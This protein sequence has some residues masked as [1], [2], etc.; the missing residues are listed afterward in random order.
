MQVIPVSRGAYGDDVVSST[1]FDAVTAATTLREQGVVLVPDAFA[2][3]APGLAEVVRGH[4]ARR[5]GID[6][7]DATTWGRPFDGGI[8]VKRFRHPE[9][10]NAVLAPQVRSVLNEALGTGRWT[11]EPASARVLVTPPRQRSH[12]QVP[13]GFH[14]DVPID[15]RAWPGHGVLLFSFLA[16]TPPGGG[17]TCVVPGSHQLIDSFLG[18]HHDLPLDRRLKV[19]LRRQ[20]EW[21]RQLV[22]EDD[23]RSDRTERCF[24]GATVGGV[25]LRVVELTGRAGDVV[26]TH[27]YTL[28]SVSPNASD[29]MRLMLSTALG[30]AD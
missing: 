14:L 30:V 8:S 17:G 27:L 15:R 26:I 20:G 1:R 7:T 23:H 24:A 12:W 5:F 6:E 13:T 4:V 11:D 3:D 2:R 19:F 21:L 10:F 22:N 16:D 29:R 18:E 9:R 25:P 28:H